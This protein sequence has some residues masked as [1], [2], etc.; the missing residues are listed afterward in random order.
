MTTAIP[1]TQSREDDLLTRLGL[2]IGQAFFLGLTLGLLAVAAIA[3]LISTYGAGILPYVYIVIAILGS[4]AFYGFAEIQRRWSLVKVSIGTELVI[5]AFLALAW[6]GLVFAQAS[7]LAFAAMV[8]FWL[9]IQIG[10]VIIGGQAGRLLDVRQIKRNFPRIVAGFVVGFMVS[11]I[12]VSPLQNW[13]GGTEYLLLA[14]AVSALIMLGMLLATNA[15]YYRILAQMSE[16]VRPQV[17]SP[18]L[19]KL[20]AKR[21]VILI[22]AYQMLS[23]MVSQL[24]DFMLLSA[25]GERYVDSDAL[26]TFFGNFTFVVNLIDLLFLALVA[27]FLLSR[28]GLKFGLIANPSIDLLI[29]A[30]IV[31]TGLFVGDSALPFFWLVVIARIVDIT[32][33]DGTTR[34][35]INATFQALPANERVTVQTGVEGI[36]VPLALGLTG[37]V[38]L[39]FDALGDTTLVHVAIFTAGVAILWIGSALYVYRDYA[40]NLIRSMRRRALDPVELNLDDKANLAVANRLLTSEKLSEVRLAL[41]MLQGAEHPTLPEQLITLVQSESTDIQIEALTRIENLKLQAALPYV[42]D[43]ALLSSDPL[44][45]GSAIRAYCALEEAETVELVTPYLDSTETEV[46]LGAAV[47]LLRYGSIPGVLAVGPRLESWEHSTDAADRC[48]LARVTGEVALPHMYQPLI[49]LLADPDP[50]VRRAALAASG[51]VRHPRLL[52]LVARN[53]DDLATRSAASDAL[54]LYGDLILPLVEQALSG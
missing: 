44:V 42:Q 22:F 29:L 50:D 5:V 35:S 27:G 37:V 54:V 40:A 18:P 46:R 41:D 34:T 30:A 53:L 21:F 20:L 4:I 51:Q 8:A 23:A 25:A 36:G 6:A 14:A 9:I 38:L 1:P 19:R 12:I 3:L 47:G 7:W 11:G 43:I 24:L 33:T 32:L 39:L 48:F 16:G 52:P 26:A 49:S 28:F 17:E 2:L 15:R 45:R 13:L 10:F 31:V